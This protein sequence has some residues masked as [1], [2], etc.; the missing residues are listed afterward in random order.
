MGVLQIWEQP[1]HT[2]GISLVDAEVVRVLRVLQQGGWRQNATK[3]FATHCASSVV[4]HALQNV[5]GGGVSPVQRA[6]RPRQENDVV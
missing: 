3:K 4:V 1:V 2:D 5:L 6:R